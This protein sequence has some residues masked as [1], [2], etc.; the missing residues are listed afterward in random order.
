MTHFVLFQALTPPRIALL[1]YEV[2][3]ATN[4]DFVASGL[5]LIQFDLIVGL[6]QLSLAQDWMFRFCLQRFLT[7]QNFKYL[8]KSRLQAWSRFCELVTVDTIG[9]HHE[10]IACQSGS[11]F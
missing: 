4:T 10:N 3:N 1:A 2:R 8:M 7:S 5:A 6:S 9:V 11:S